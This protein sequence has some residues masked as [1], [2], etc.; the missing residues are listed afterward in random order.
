[1][2][3]VLTVPRAVVFW[4]LLP[5]IR[6]RGSDLLLE[7]GIGRPG[8]NKNAWPPIRWAFFLCFSCERIMQKDALD[9]IVCDIID[10]LSFTEKV[11][12][13]RI[14]GGGVATLA[15]ELRRRILKSLGSDHQEI[16]AVATEIWQRLRRTHGLRV[17]K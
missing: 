3:W 2:C 5:R 12:I 10:E 14:N 9:Q 11:A 13:A 8:T 17:V 16:V 6:F 1:M 15:Q 7:C 4:L